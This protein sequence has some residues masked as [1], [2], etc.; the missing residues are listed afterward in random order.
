MPKLDVSVFGLE[1]G[2]AAL[3]KY[4]AVTH[5]TV[6]VYGADGGLIAGPAHRTPLFDLFAGGHEPGIFWKC[7]RACLDQSNAGS[8]VV[9]EEGHGLAVVGT[10]LMLAG[11]IVGAAVAGYG[12]TMHPG[13]REITRLARDSRLAFDDVWAVMRKQLPVPRSR[14]P[15]HGELLGIIGD[16][17]LSEHYRS[18]QLEE[19][20]MRVAQASEAKDQFLAVLSH[21]LRTPLTAILGYV[22][23]LRIGKLEE[24]AADRALEAIDR[25]AKLQTRLIEDLLDV[26]RIISGTLR[27]RAEPIGLAPVLETAVANVRLG[28]QTKGISLDLVLGP[29]AGMISGDPL[30]MQQIVSNLLVNAIKFTP[31]GGKIEVRLERNG[32]EVQIIVKDTGAGIR[33]DFLPYVF[34]RFRQDDTT[35]AR[36]HGGLGLGLAIVRHLVELHD[37]SIC[38]ESPGQD[39]GATFTIS[40]P[41]LV[42]AE[43]RF[44]EPV[45]PTTGSSEAMD[46][47]PTLKG[48]RVLVVDD[49]A[50]ARDLFTS[51][52]EQCEAQVTAVASAGAA[53][54]ALEGWNPDVLVSDIGMP[55]ESGYVLI[56]KVR[57]LT[58]EQGGKIPALALT[59]YAGVDDV[60]LALAA[61]FQA[62]LAKPVEPVLLA[63]AVA[64]LARGIST[65]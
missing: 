9:I 41:A 55:K 16:T 3:E 10:A 38:A 36:S 65:S 15:L 61:G 28:A 30:R 32:L 51:A 62:H 50:D 35:E 29:S 8:A 49:D 4:G 60:K 24:R 48:L 40:L 5:L 12:L 26:S 7:A 31:P 46:D 37:G 42:G 14:L 52:L 18:R 17:L 33:R 57:R 47:P 25:N 13:P 21:E 1:R 22:R 64:D 53:L 43:A 44:L 23:I 59:A 27:L 11:E 6:Q 19:A 39:Q 45:A 63:L 58:R 20:S 34:D 54:T 2:R 56:R